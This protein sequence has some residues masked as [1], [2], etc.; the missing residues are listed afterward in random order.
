MTTSD[1]VA[2]RDEIDQLRRLGLVLFVDTATLL[3][4]CMAVLQNHVAG[5]ENVVNVMGPVHGIAYLTYVWT[6]IQTVSDG[7]WSR[8]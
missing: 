1:E 7:G 4:L 3:L 6:A 2:R 8:G 5:N